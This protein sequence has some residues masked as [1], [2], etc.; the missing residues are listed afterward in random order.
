MADK[1]LGV[2]FD[3]VT[4]TAKHELGIEAEDVR[5]GNYGLSISQIDQFP[6]GP[7]TTT[8]TYFPGNRYKY[9]QAS[10]TI[11]IGDAVKIDDAAAD[12]TK[13]GL[14]TPTTA[15]TD[16]VDGVA[17]V[18]IA[19]GSFGWITIKGRVNSAKVLDAGNAEGAA[20]GASGT[21]GT[22]VAITAA[23]PTAAEVIAAIRGGYGR[24]AMSLEDV[25]TNLWNVVLRG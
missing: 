23:T 25:G 1:F 11:A 10:A 24:R 15:V 16:I 7:V 4:T 5:G 13:P 17:H 12:L 8:R 19:S 20:L 3:V 2:D 18:A 9:V 6:G 21:A 14:V 22:L